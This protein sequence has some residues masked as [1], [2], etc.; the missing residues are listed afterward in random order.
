MKKFLL[1][2]SLSMLLVFGLAAETTT[3]GGGSNSVTVLSSSGSETVLQYQIGRFEQTRVQIGG[4]DWYH[5]NLPKEGITQDKGAPQLPVFNRSIII[6]PT[7]RMRLELSDVQYQDFPVAV[8]PSKGVITRDIDPATVPYSF[9]DVYQRDEFYPQN[10]AE[11]SEPYIMRDFRGI[12]VQT[13]PFAYNPKTKTLRVYTSYKVRVYASGQDTVNTL[14][15]DRS[16]ISRDFVSLY[17]NRFLNWDSFRYTPVDDSFG[18]LLVICHTNYMSTILPYVNW[19]IQKGIPT[20]LVQWSTIGTTAAQLQTYIQNR[21]N[22]DSELTY[23]QLVGDAPQIPSLSSGGGGSDPTFSLVAGSDNYPDIFIGRFSAETTA[24][25]TAQ[26][27]KA[28]AYERDVTTSDTWLSRAMGIA[29]AEGGGSLGDE[30]ESDIVHM[31]NI[32]TDLLG[33]GYTSIDQIY[34]PGASAST[35][36]T[37][38][39]A[40]R[41]FINYVGHG[42]DTYWVTTGF[43]NTNATALTNGTKT[44]FIMDVACVNGNFVSITC[45]AEAWQRN[46]N[47]GSVAI[48]ASSINQSWNSPMRA[49]DEVTDLLIAEAKYTVGGLYYNGSCEMM[50]VYGTD[51]VNMFKTWHIFGDASLSSRTKTPIAMSVTHPS[52]ITSGTTSVSVSTGVNNTLVAITYNNVIYG[53]AFT[54]S[55]GN[56][57]ITLTSPPT[58]VLNYTIT[59]TAHNRVTYV[60]TIAQTVASGPWMEVT[61]A[62]FDDANNDVPEYNESGYFDVT[63]K[64]SGTSAASS[65]SATLSCA[66]SGI[67]VTD[68]S[69]SISSLAAGASTTADNAYAIA[70]A[71]NVANGTV[72]EFT[73]IMT[74]SGYGPWTYNFSKT[75]NAPALAFGNMT[76]SDLSGDNDGLL[77]PGETATIAIV[78]NNTGAAAS[79]AGTGTLSCGTSGITVVN[80]SA[81]F[82]AISAG[83]YATLSFT[84]TAA[85]SMTEGTLAAFV[86]NAV[87]GQ[88]SANTTVNVEVGA[89]L[90]VIIGNGTS[91]QS[92]PIDRY[93]NYSGHEAIYLASEIG[94]PG[95]IKSIGFYKAS[96]TDVNT[97]EAVTVYMKN[98]SSTTLSTGNYSTSG[99]TQVYSGIWPNTATSGWMEVNLQ[100][101]FAYDGS[102]LSILTIKG[103]QSYIT[104]YPYWT[105]TTASATRARQNRSD[106][107][108]PT[109][110]TASTNLPNLKLK[111]FP[112]AGIL[113]PPQNLAATATHGS[114]TL[115]WQAPVSGTPNGYKVYKNNAALST[116]TALT[117]TDTAVTDGTTYSYK[118]SA[119]YGSDESDPAATVT[120]TPNMHAPTNLVATGGNSVVM[121]SWTAATGREAEDTFTLGSKDRA[122]SSYRIYRN[123]AVLTTVTGTSYNDTGVTNGTTYNY[124]VTTL[125]TNPTGESAASNTASATP[126]AV[127]EAIIGS[128]TGSN[129]TTIAC[130]INVYYESLHGQSVFTAAELTAAGVTGPIQITQI[131]FNVT[132]L[133]TLAMPN[134]VV[135]MGHTTSANVA[136]WISTG[137]TQVWSS[138]SYLPTNTGWN[139]LTLATPFT[140]N[141][142]DNILIDTAFGDIGDWEQSGTTQYTNVTNGYRYVR[143]DDADQTDVFTGGSTSTYRPNVKLV[144]LPQVTGPAIAVNPASVSET[145]VEGNSTTA[146]VTVTNSGTA[147]LTWST[148]SSFAAWGTV[149]PASG[150][151]AAGGN[152]VLTLTLNAAA[153]TAGSY[154]ANMV[155]TSNAANTPSLTVPV[156]LTVE[157]YVEPSDIRF[158]AE[159]EPATGT[160]IAY[161]G[162]FGLPYSMI[163][164]LSTRGE[165]YVLVTSSTQSTASSLL[166]SNGVTMSNVSFIVRDGVNTYWTRDYGPWSIFDANG[167]MAIV[168]FRYNRVRPYDDAVNAVLDD[169]FGFGYYYM[170]M[171]A[172]GG[173]VMTDGQGKM[174]STTLIQNENDGVQT[175]AVTEYDYTLAEIADVV[176]QYL[177]VDEYFMYT[178]PLS[179][180]SIDHIDCHAKLLDVD[181]VMIAR[182]PVGHAN[183]TALENVVDYWETKTSSYGT[184]YQIFRVDQT[185]SNEPYA[186]SFI[187][188]NKIYVPQASSTA[189]AADLAAI[190]AYQAAMPGYTVQGY[191]NSSF[192]SDDAAHCRVN[193]VFDEQMIHLAHVQPTSATANSNVTID[194]EISHSNP[195]NTSSTYIAYRHSTTGQWLTVPLTLVSGDDWTASVP[196][197]A[198]GEILYY[199][200]LATDNTART[201]KMPLC[202]ADDPLELLVDTAGSNTAPTIALPASFTFAEDGS[203]VVDFSQY[204]DD[205]DS[206]PLTLSYS[207]DDQVNV[208][209]NGL[210]VTFTADADWYGTDNISFTV[211]DGTDSASDNVNVIVT[212]VTDPAVM[213][214]APLSLAYGEDE[215]GST[216]VKTFTITNTGE[217]ALNGSITTPTGYSVAEAGRSESLITEAGENLKTERNTLSFSVASGVTETYNLTFAPTAAIAYN[218][219]VTVSGNDPDNSSDLITITG[220]GHITNTAPTIALPASFSFEEDGSL[221]V[222]FGQYVEDGQTPDSG[223]SL[224][225]SGNSNVT[226]IIDGL[227]GTFSALEN[228]NGTETLTFTIGDGELSSSDDVNVIVTPVND[229][230]TIALPASFSF[231]EDGSLVVDFSG[232]VIDVDGDPLNL[233][234]S[235]TSNVTVSI[236]ELSVTFGAP[237]NWNGTETL[238]FTIGDGTLSASDAVS[239]I[240]APINDAP[241]IALPET[242]EFDQNGSLVVD[243][244]QY[245]DDIDGDA[246]SLSSSGNSNVMV[247]IV[248]LSVTFTAPTDWIGT[249]TLAFTVSDGSASAQ[250]EA[251]VTVILTHLDTPMITSIVKTATGIQIE[252]QPVANARSYRVYRSFDPYGDYTDFRGTTALTEFVDSDMD[253]YPYAFYKIVATD[254]EYESK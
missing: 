112:A 7:A 121:L 150:T 252:W 138:A 31:N 137:L 234:V 215:V 48:Y 128:G 99:Y 197:P 233:S 56:A 156:S 1:F 149:S 32:R 130:P 199:Y 131:G 167:E 127:T 78:L 113:Y 202:G 35:V 210:S 108:Q 79:L 55:S 247:N 20:E 147:A 145:A 133:P 76:I 208:A 142:T 246:L 57:T 180:S 91:T 187:F 33:Y 237:E 250:D 75:I 132:G 62:N 105:Y 179:N 10:V 63:F 186:N 218:G 77:D 15:T 3:L 175:A 82:S 178:D 6:D 74:M 93:Y 144:L 27:N 116:V 181:K 84:V 214:V 9:G 72:A 192:I 251:D 206:D 151:V 139:M 226:V 85:S 43:S 140:W 88:Y 201:A 18:K 159:W 59:A 236:D 118:V 217:A 53:R 11:L 103:Y 176:E 240:V 120:A 124:Y 157:A 205:V 184:P 185:S 182:V 211:S 92:Y 37:N 219:N 216:S 21:Y 5:I 19:K 195:L 24:Q 164:D 229:V 114:V 83:G 22:A 194:V 136:S 171:V 94:T 189:S 227:S 58:G 238:T 170:P 235:G 209:I 125:Y 221:V 135:R 123:G 71:N 42:A 107:S 8:A 243:F 12:V 129:G 231:E 39:N 38:V 143:S 241:T 166:S 134:F 161:S 66:T 40:G 110:L 44:P 54:N 115:T 158:I 172:T 239:V 222:D 41:G 106:S 25:V 169:E 68:A 141:G 80:G 87:A 146:T 67:T 213:V 100:N 177:G 29:S 188:N 117:Y 228:W 2:L 28:I 152:T 30:G 45:F 154:N 73:V 34:D 81:S 86:F 190:A 23:V 104:S 50:D 119:L 193:T 49:E 111:L 165:V 168:D 109:S 223:L 64:N 245:L 101:Q 200:I 46:A 162:G 232:Y 61:A 98:T 203:L 249:E 97:I 36:T 212:S 207:G 14:T 102:N 26:I 17:E 153:L 89:P 65:V 244:S 183:Y 230:P 95:T 204:V 13:T 242:F 122:I 148:P 196:T 220:L 225:V 60:G 224:S 51:G 254:L 126:N 52:N 4:E 47:G 253:V 16:S 160:I 96:G 248:G 90:E 191:Y 173:N 163:A 198:Y 70:I 155:I 174:M 69:H